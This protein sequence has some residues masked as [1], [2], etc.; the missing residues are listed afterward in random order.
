MVHIFL[1]V[2]CEYYEPCPEGKDYT[3]S[4]L[5]CEPVKVSLLKDFGLNKKWHAPITGLCQFLTVRR[6]DQSSRAHTEPAYDQK[7]KYTMIVESLRP[8]GER[9]FRSCACSRAHC[10]MRVQGRVSG[11][12]SRV[13]RR[14]VQRVCKDRPSG[15][16]EN[17]KATWH[18]VA[19]C[20]FT[21]WP[22]NRRAPD[23]PRP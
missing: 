9:S 22:L 6:E 14:G 18:D 15:R 13:Q 17:K 2:M 23:R 5:G 4:E 10:S 19:C 1:Y 3:D 16:N 11:R 21:A 8:L 20:C 12:G 7:R